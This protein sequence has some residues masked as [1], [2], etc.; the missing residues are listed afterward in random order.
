[1]LFTMTIAITAMIWRK[2][3]SRSVE[4]LTVPRPIGMNDIIVMVIVGVDFF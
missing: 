3:W 2:Y 4:P 1:M